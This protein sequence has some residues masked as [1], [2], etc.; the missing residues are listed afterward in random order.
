MRH[1]IPG[2][3]LRGV[4]NAARF[5]RASAAYRSFS[6]R[7]D[8]VALA[9]RVGQCRDADNLLRRPQCTA[10]DLREP[11]VVNPQP[12]HARLEKPSAADLASSRRSQ[13]RLGAISSETIYRIGQTPGQGLRSRTSLPLQFANSLF[14]T[15]G[16]GP[17]FT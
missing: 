14:E 17:Y 11:R 12:T 4:N 7:G 3:S 8:Y 16:T 13:R 10:Y 6:G 5:W 15:S 9:G 2:R 1:F